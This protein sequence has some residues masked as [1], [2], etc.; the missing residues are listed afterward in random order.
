ML[1]TVRLGFRSLKLRVR[2]YDLKLDLNL[3]LEF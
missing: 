1:L 2:G 3:D